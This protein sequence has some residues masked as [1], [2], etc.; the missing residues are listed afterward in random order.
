MD[1]EPGGVHRGAEPHHG[2]DDAHHDPGHDQ[3][4]E[5][6]PFHDPTG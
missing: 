5:V 4:D 1:V 2:P 3:P 6:G